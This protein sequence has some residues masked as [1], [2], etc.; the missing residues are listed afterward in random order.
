MELVYIVKPFTVCEFLKILSMELVYI[1]KPMFSKYLIYWVKYKK[2]ASHKRF[3]IIPHPSQLFFNAL[4]SSFVCFS[5]GMLLLKRRLL[6]GDRVITIQILNTNLR[7]IPIKKT[8]QNKDIVSYT[9]TAGSEPHTKTKNHCL[10]L[11]RQ[12][13]AQP[14]N[15]LKWE[16]KRRYREIFLPFFSSSF[17]KWEVLEILMLW[18]SQWLWQVIGSGRDPG[19]H[20]EAKECANLERDWG[21]WLWLCS[22]VVHLCLWNRTRL[23][24]LLLSSFCSGCRLLFLQFGKNGWLTLREWRHLF[25]HC[26]LLDEMFNLGDW[27]SFMIKGFSLF[28]LEIRLFFMIKGLSLF[29][30]I[31]TWLVYDQGL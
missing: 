3:L 7:K 15:R 10:S 5:S 14:E 18:E 17:D 6:W 25:E 27:F 23:L 4:F 1:A 28:N 24:L 13:Y 21:W 31:E 11:T 12:R 8:V 16:W 30:F 9:Y 22:S 20:E 29:N 2:C 26:G 19:L